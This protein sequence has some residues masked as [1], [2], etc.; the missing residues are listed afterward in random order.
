MLK[1]INIDWLDDID[2]AKAESARTGR[3]ILMFFHY[4][5]CQG[6]INTFER[7]LPKMSVSNEITENFVP[8]LLETSERLVD[9]A[10]YRVD[11]TPTFIVADDTAHEIMRWE[12]FL[13]EDDFLAQLAMAEAK[14]AFKMQ[15]YANAERLFDLVLLKF[16]L[17]DLAPEAVYYQG[18]TKYK[19]S[20]NPVWLKRAYESLRGSYPGSVWTLKAS[21]FSGEKMTKAA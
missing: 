5:L 20:M 1:E 4:K 18:V 11:W 16:P 9:V 3:P 19:A 21:V 12:G 6:C 10:K 13:P 7:T 8:V 2:K 15:D 14:V 17:T